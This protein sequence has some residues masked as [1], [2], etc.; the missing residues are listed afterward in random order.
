MKKLAVLSCIVGLVAASTQSFAAVKVVRFVNGRKIIETIDQEAAWARRVA[1]RSAPQK[2]KPR[3][4]A[5]VPAGYYRNRVAKPNVARALSQE[6]HYVRP[7]EGRVAQHATPATQTPSLT[8]YVER[9]V[10]RSERLRLSGTERASVNAV[11][12]AWKDAGGKMLYDDQIKL[13]RDV[14]EFYEK[15]GQAGKRVV[16][17]D[18]LELVRYDL[19]TERMVIYRAGYDNIEVLNADQYCIIYDPADHYG[20]VISMGALEMFVPAR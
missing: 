13:V 8:Q 3:K 7:N 9:A 19:P 14:V 20:Q 2:V 17:P 5:S 18:G 1:K 4:L 6:L 12:A 16:G 11:R 15:Q 10:A